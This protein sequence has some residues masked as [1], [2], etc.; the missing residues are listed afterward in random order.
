MLDNCI[1]TLNTD[2][3]VV[4]S[5]SGDPPPLTCNWR[6]PAAW[7]YNPVPDAWWNEYPGKV[8]ELPEFAVNL[9]ADTTP[10]TSNIISDDPVT[11]KVL[12]PTI[13]FKAT[14]SADVLAL[15]PNLAPLYKNTSLN[16]LLNH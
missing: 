6:Y 13:C 10:F 12:V 14:R 7:E 8:A 16:L 1:G 4:N 2:W 3:P 9:L 15:Q 5:N 11:C